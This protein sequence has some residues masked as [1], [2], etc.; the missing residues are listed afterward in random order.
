MT[1]GEATITLKVAKMVEPMVSLVV[2]NHNINNRSKVRH[3]LG[4]VLYGSHYWLISNKKWAFCPVRQSATIYS[5]TF[6]P[7]FP[8]SPRPL[9]Q[10]QQQFFGPTHSQQQAFIAPQQFPT[11]NNEQLTSL[12]Q[13]FNAMA[14]NDPDTGGCFM[15]TR[16]TSHLRV[17]SG[18][19]KSISYN[20]VFPSSILVGDGSSIP[21]IKI[22]DTTLLLPN[23]YHT[24][25]LK[26]ILVSPQIIKN[27]IYVRHFTLDNKCIIEFEPFGFF[28]GGSLDPSNSNTM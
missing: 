18:I 28:C 27:L 4:G 26:N 3:L 10:H 12:H 16:A 17:D 15:D 9:A 21:V 22:G 25:L 1:V 24:L 14:F 11:P 2:D 8:N 13:M 20:N 7:H 23:P 6:I 5:A 19:L